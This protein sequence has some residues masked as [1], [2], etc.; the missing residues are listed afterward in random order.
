[1]ATLVDGGQR[2][3][4][5]DLDAD[6]EDQQVGL[7]AISRDVE[8]LDLRREAKTVGEAERPQG[9]PRQQCP[10]SRQVR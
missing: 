3:Q 5:P 1:M 6:V 2:E 10:K 4:L 9:R 8:L 7:Q